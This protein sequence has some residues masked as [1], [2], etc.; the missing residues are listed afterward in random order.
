MMRET[1][2]MRALDYVTEACWL[3]ALIAIPIYFDILTVRIFEPDKIV[4]FR[5]IVLLMVL[6]ALLRL[7]LGAPSLLASSKKTA[8]ANAEGAGGEVTASASKTPLWR[9]VLTSRPMLLPVGIFVVIYA[10][11]TVHSVLPGISFWGSYDRMEGFYTWLN[12]IA[13]FLVLSYRLRT[14]IQIERIVNALIFTSAPIAFY[15]IM[16]HLQWDPLPWGADTTVRVA[17]TLG[18]SIFLGAYLLMCMPFAA[19]RIW[20]AAELLRPAPAAPPPPSPAG[21]PARTRQAAA[22]SRQSTATPDPL[23]VWGTIAFYGVILLIDFLAIFF[24]GSK[25]PYYGLCAAIVVMGVPLTLKFAKPLPFI[26]AIVLAIAVFGIP[27]GLN[28]ISST[29]T[30][31]AAGSSGASI[32][33][34]AQHLTDVGGPTSQTRQFIWKGSL[35]LISHNP[36]L[37]YGPETMIYVYAPYYPP[38]LGH[39]EHSNAAP[40]RNHDLWLDF[41]VF[42]GILGLLAWFGVLGGFGLTIWRI[43]KRTSSSRVTLLLATVLGVV[44]G[45]LVE[46]SVGIPIVSTLMVQWTMFGLATAVLARPD[47]LAQRAVVPATVTATDAEQAKGRKA[48]PPPRRG[49]RP[50]V[51]VPVSPWARLTG[52]QRGG[53]IGGGVALVIATLLGVGLFGNNLQVVRADAAYK[54]GQGYDNAASAC[55]GQLQ[56]QATNLQCP[57]QTQQQQGQPATQAVQQQIGNYTSQILLPQALSSFGEAATDQPNQDMYDLWMGKTY[58]DKATYDLITNNRADAVTQFGNA[59]QTLMTARSLNPQN[60]DH[61]M[62]LA[63]MYSLW[64]QSIDPSKWVDA[65]KY[66]AIA[67][68]LARHNGRWFDEWGHADLVQAQ[69]A[70]VTGT[71]KTSIL[72]RALTAFTQ[73]ANVDDQLGDARAY[74][75]D[76]QAQL[77]LYAAAAAS[78]RE[79]LRVGGFE[80]GQYQPQPGA[81]VA[82][83]IAANLFSNLSQAHD[84][85]GMTTPD[86]Y[87]PGP[88][89]GQ[90][91]VTL[92]YSPTVA[93]LSAGSP[94]SSTVNAG[95]VAIATHG[96][97][98]AA[99]ADLTAPAQGSLLLQAQS[100]TLQA[101]LSALYVAKDYKDLVASVYNKQSLIA[102]AST[103]AIALNAPTSPFAAAL[104][105]IQ[106]T[107]RQKG[108]LK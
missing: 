55:I 32:T 22:N 93:L 28:F 27:V 100:P 108:Y 103:P 106:T 13:F 85:K 74:R 6:A 73:A 101:V 104:T 34:D 33:A 78:Y 51:V 94:Y 39:L 102:L 69:R 88:G 67:T 60:A 2:V 84:Y 96:Y 71:V 92:A 77:T 30:A 49:P 99:V 54:T 23:P 37:G 18:N 89:L 57:Q 3:L 82:S 61:P 80:Q 68:D 7:L 43:F 81:G 4:L 35:P 76:A 17:S 50:A 66:F 59:E 95:I 8:A 91:A 97:L 5:N 53:I 19:Y 25:G 58:L 14:W 83:S 41:L 42:S 10:L 24:S 45:D 56:N 75:G 63:R 65:D 64:A 48:A 40:D 20:R 47:L 52:R 105:T 9:T 46:G 29:S 11:A 1:T 12:Y 72:R 26:G 70:N 21:R 38:G 62:N 31:A 36:L 107:L 79:A 15:G 16:Q 44:V 86:A 90:A 87:V 98:H